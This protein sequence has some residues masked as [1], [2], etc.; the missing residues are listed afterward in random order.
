MEEE[1]FEKKHEQDVAAG[2]PPEHNHHF[3]LGIPLAVREAVAEV[4]MHVG[5][6]KEARH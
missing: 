2:H 3:S 6:E 5:E 1:H 4:R